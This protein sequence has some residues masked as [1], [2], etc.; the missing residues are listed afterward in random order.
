VVGAVAGF[1]AFGLLST[2]LWSRS[3]QHGQACFVVVAAVW[4]A[5]YIAYRFVPVRSPLWS[6]LSVGVLATA[7]YLWAAIRPAEPGLPPP[8]PSSHFLRVLPIQYISIGAAA[9]VAMFWYV[10]L[11]PAEARAGGGHS[12]ELD[13]RAG[14]AR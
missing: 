1:L 6:I 3:I 4:I 10:H 5:V 7:G 8:I 9:A 11:P 2:G 14:A 13:S 12:L